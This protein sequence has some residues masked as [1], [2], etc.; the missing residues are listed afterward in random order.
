MNKQETKKKEQRK[1]KRKVHLFLSTICDIYT[2]T[3]KGKRKNV[4]QRGKILEAKREM[5][6]LKH[7]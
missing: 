5:R 3:S 2:K 7:F 6:E 4:L 1:G